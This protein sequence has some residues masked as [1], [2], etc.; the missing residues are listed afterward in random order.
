MEGIL[1]GVPG[2]APVCAHMVGL[3]HDLAEI[4]LRQ[5]FADAYLTLDT[6]AAAARR[7]ARQAFAEVFG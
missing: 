1:E 2:L 5:R 7:P 3:C 6:A 4:F